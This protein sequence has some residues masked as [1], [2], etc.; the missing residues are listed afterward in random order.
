MTSD[1]VVASRLGI[2]ALL[3]FAAGLEREWSG[4]TSGADARFAG[5]RT[6]VVL[7]LCGGV[8][9][10]LSEA[11]HE[12]GGA[13]VMAAAG[14]LCVAGYWMAARRPTATTDGTTEA[15][16]VSV[17][18]LSMLAGTGRI[19]V[20][21]GAGAIVTLLLREKERLHWFVRR[22]GEPELRAAVQ[23]TALAVVVLPLLPTGPY[24]GWLQLRPRELWTVV[25]A[26]CALN[27]AAFVARRVVGESRGL[28]VTGALGGM[29]S[30]TAVTLAYSRRSREGEQNE[31]SLASGVMAAC[32]VMA[33]RV[34]SVSTAFNVEAGKRLAVFVAPMFA[35][36]TLLV[37]RDWSRGSP[38]ERSL[39]AGDG[40]PL[41]LAAAIR[42]TLEFQAAM[43][44]ISLVGRAD[45]ERG[46]YAS[47]ALLGLT[48]VDA[49]TI[50]LSRP[51]AGIAAELAARAI[52]VG[53]VANT[54]MKLTIAAVL[55]A[56]GFRWRAARGLAL[57]AAGGIAG[58]LLP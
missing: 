9:G 47:G 46:L 39:A 8:A 16:A 51:E 6:F 35:I 5:V 31:R 50:S 49:L 13:I 12:A 14:A 4:H 22:L 40:N 17:I 7:A 26:L 43:V 15:A 34:V 24:G 18:A 20:A 30:S 36:G 54:M 32:T 27:F 58:F 1:L 21:A 52:L 53:V 10:V 41:R 23:F 44:L 29:I 42:L 45:G 57:L 2:A 11:G 38:G 19:G 55:G 25:L 56:R 33:P 3:G 37:I 28:A 48:D